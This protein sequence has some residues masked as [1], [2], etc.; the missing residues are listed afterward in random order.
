MRWVGHVACEGDKIS[1]C[2]VLVGK[3]CRKETC[4]T[5]MKGAWV[6]RTKYKWLVF[7]FFEWREGMLQQISQKIIPAGSSIITV[8]LFVFRNF[9]RLQWCF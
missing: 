7:N 4:W 6:I 8:N 3:H 2:R 1:S 9:S 5:C